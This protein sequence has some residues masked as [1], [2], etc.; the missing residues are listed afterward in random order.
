M[1][2]FLHSS[3]LLQKKLLQFY[4]SFPDVTSDIYFQMLP[5]NKFSYSGKN[6][7]ESNIILK[8]FLSFLNTLQKWYLTS[9]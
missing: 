4:I 9:C 6:S 7:K 2:I 3:L 5:I 1:K 8:L